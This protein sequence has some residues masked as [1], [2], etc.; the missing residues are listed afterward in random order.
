[1]FLSTF[2]PQHLLFNHKPMSRN[3]IWASTHPERFQIPIKLE[4]QS[5]VKTNGFD[6]MLP[7][8]FCSSAPHQG[9]EIES[10]FSD[11][12]K[13]SNPNMLGPETI[14]KTMVFSTFCP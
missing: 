2:R 3:G 11:T 14:V 12:P 9:I 1:M 4:P 8:A 13:N 5:T 10:W 7:L 6:H